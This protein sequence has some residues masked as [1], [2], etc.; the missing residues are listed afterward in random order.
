MGWHHIWYSC[1]AVMSTLHVSLIQRRAFSLREP[2][3]S[4]QAS[5]QIL[6]ASNFICAFPH[7][8]KQYWEDHLGFYFNQVF[9]KDV[10][11]VL[12]FLA[13]EMVYLALFSFSSDSGPLISGGFIWLILVGINGIQDWHAA[14]DW[15]RRWLNPCWLQ[16]LFHW[17]SW[18]WCHHSPRFI[19]SPLLH[20]SA[21]S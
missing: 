8:T 16:S 15:W 10:D 3:G 2:K 4:Y 11:F 12:I 6:C 19:S 5:V 18:Q 21:K 7:N 14:A 1:F 9:W 17:L 13:M 20:F